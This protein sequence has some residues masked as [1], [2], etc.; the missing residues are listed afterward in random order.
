MEKIKEFL[1]SIG[2][3]KNETEIYV[4]LVSMGTSSVLDIAKRTKIHRS[5]IYDS[6]RKLVEGGLVYEINGATKLF[7][8]REPKS[9]VDFLSNKQAEL[10]EIIKDFEMKAQKKPKEKVAV[11][12]GIF[13]IREALFNLINE[14]KEIYAYGIPKDAS[15][16]V[17]PKLNDFHKERVK[18]KISMFHIYNSDAKERVEYLKSLEFT[19]ARVLP[20]KYDTFTMTLVCGDKVVLVF[21][22]DE[23]MVLEICDANL[24]D[25]YKNYFEI[26]WKKAK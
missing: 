23:P 2:F 11:S 17:G 20:P 5:N 14:K 26:L 13:A 10:A 4:T 6:I 25:S 19:D 15:E 1:S 21:W 3:G 12:K 24:A 18:Q 7:Q 16:R 22:E 9:L 8:A